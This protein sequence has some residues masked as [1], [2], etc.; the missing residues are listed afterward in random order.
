MFGLSPCGGLGRLQREPS[1]EMENGT[2]REI[3]ER[4]SV[5]LGRV[6]LCSG[7]YI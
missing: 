3:K 4:V 1:N 5:G 2:S 6:G 7:I